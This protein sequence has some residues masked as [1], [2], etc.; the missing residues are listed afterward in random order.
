MFWRTGRR[1]G[2]TIYCM[3]GVV[4][5]D[6]DELIGMMDSRSLAE[7]AVRGHNAELF[8]N[9]GEREPTP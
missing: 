3:V 1:V 6:K 7:A 4:A 2:R 5:T 9:P 8:R